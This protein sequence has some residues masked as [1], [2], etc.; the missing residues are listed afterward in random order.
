MNAT[1]K[2][3]LYNCAATVAKPVGMYP[4]PK[5]YRRHLLDILE[6][7][8]VNCVI[9]VGAH[10]GEWGE[11]VRGIG[12][13]GTILS[14]EPVSASFERLKRAARNDKKWKIYP[15][16]L[17]EAGCTSSIHVYKSSDFSSILSAGA[18]AGDRFEH[19][20]ETM[21]TESIQVR[22]LDECLPELDLSGA[23]IYLKVDTQGY[24]QK[25]VAGASGILDRVIAMQSELP[26]PRPIYREEPALTES[27][28]YYASLGYFPTGFFP[29]LHQDGDVSVIGFDVVFTRPAT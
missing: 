7:L 8:Q 26:G 12:Y 19:D 6:A 17:G 13:K 16:A 15:F 4:F 3:Y 27:L 29:L 21:R 14:F 10:F 22:R 5:T 9:D 11:I 2:S 25:V 20:V 18:S 24:D 23:K 1:L 28:A